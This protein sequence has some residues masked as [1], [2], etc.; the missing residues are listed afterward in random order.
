MERTITVRTELESILVEQAL[1]MARELEALTDA[2]PDGAVLAVGEMWPPSGWAKRADPHRPGGRPAKRPGELGLPAEKKGGSRPT[3]FLPSL[4]RPAPRQAARSAPRARGRDRRRRP[5]RRRPPVD[6]VPRVRHDGLPGRRPDRP[7]R[8]SSARAPVRLACRVAAD[9]SFAIAADRLEQL[10]GIRLDDRTIRRHVHRAAAATAAR[11]EADPPGAAFAAA[12][13]EAE[14]L[15][16]GVMTPTRSGW[17]ELE[18]GR[19]PGGGRRASRPPRRG[20][21]PWRELPAATA[22]AAYAALADCEAF[23]AR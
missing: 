19:L 11:R 18:A 8:A 4:R 7:R 12:E 21:R 22:V 15:A 5:G 17:R 20:G 14:F 9:H 10:C 3:P 23:A 13:G 6:A 2:A 16:D 1:A